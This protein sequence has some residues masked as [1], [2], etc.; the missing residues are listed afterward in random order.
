MTPRSVVPVTRD[1]AMER[2]LIILKP[3]CL[4]RSLVGRM[5]SRL[6]DK[7][8]Q[9]VAMKMVK[10]SK[11]LAHRHYE[12]HRARPFFAP[13][14]EFMTSAPVIVMALEG[15][16][17]VDICR[18]LVGATFGPDAAAGTIR[19]DFGISRSFNLIHGSDSTEAARRELDLFFSESEIHSHERVVSSWLYSREDLGNRS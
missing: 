10:I 16:G 17:A 2:T 15:P 5:I 12:A 19:G 14:V 9:I 7:G 3:D 13:L 1:C 8:L 6:E 4:Q 11:D 18:K